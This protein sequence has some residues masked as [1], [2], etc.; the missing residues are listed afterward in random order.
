[1]MAT[2]TTSNDNQS[3]P[4]KTLQNMGARIRS[5]VFNRSISFFVLILILFENIY[6]FVFSVLEKAV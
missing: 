2:S 1:M 6:L 3:Q 4:I 5:A